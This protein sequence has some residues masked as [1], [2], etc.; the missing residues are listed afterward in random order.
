MPHGM[1]T[2][3]TPR[4]PPRQAPARRRQLL[5][6]SRFCLFCGCCADVFLVNLEKYF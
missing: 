6:F 3:H 1:R 2:A 4:T 5:D